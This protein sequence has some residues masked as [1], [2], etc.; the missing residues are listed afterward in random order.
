MS[1]NFCNFIHDRLGGFVRKVDYGTHTIKEIDRQYNVNVPDNMLQMFYASF[2]SDTNFGKADMCL[3]ERLVDTYSFFLLIQLPGEDDIVSKTEELAH[4][5]RTSLLD[6]VNGD[7]SFLN[8]CAVSI[9]T[10]TRRVQMVWNNF[11]IN[12]TQALTMREKLVADL[13]YLDSEKEDSINE[14]NWHDRIEYKC[15]L[16]DPLVVAGSKNLITCNSCKN[17]KQQRDKCSGCLMRGFTYSETILVPNFV[18]SFDTEERRSLL[19]SETIS[20]S[21][22]LLTTVTSANAVSPCMNWVRPFGTPYYHMENK[23]PHAAP[24][25]YP[26]DS[27]HD[28]NNHRRKRNAPM[29]DVGRLKLIQ[30]VIRKTHA[31]FHS[32]ILVTS[33]SVNVDATQKKIYV[34]PLGTGIHSCVKFNGEHKD[35]RVYFTITPS[36]VQQCCVSKELLPANREC[37]SKSG[38]VVA[39]NS[40]MRSCLFPNCGEKSVSIAMSTGYQ[41]AC[42]VSDHCYLKLHGKSKKRVNLWGF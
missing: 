39:M 31:K 25:V 17:K 4:L 5:I 42:Q 16:N 13:A 36:G 6:F 37:K 35:C 32:K 33:K 41:L 24:K 18:Y 34:Y 1:Q 10:R 28:Y 22:I 23:N 38:Q 19:G 26:T 3:Y 8:V 7:P 14:Y 9:C 27:V 30:K 40:Q 15:Y 11:K 20:G 29:L 12:T 21:D 2:A